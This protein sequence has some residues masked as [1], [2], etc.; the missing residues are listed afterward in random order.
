MTRTWHHA[1][2]ALSLDRCLVMAVVNVTPDSFHDGGRWIVE[3]RSRPNV[4]VVVGQCRRWVEQGADIL[5]VGGESTRPGADPVDEATEL[6]R[7]LPIIE[8]LRA[9]PALA[10]VPISVDTRHAVV[11]RQALKAGAAIVNDISG[12]ADPAM[13]EVVAATG[14]GLV[15]SHLRGEPATMQARV[16][17]DDLLGE[18]ADE[19]E[20]AVARA[21]AAGVAREQIVLDP[22]IGFGKTGAQSAAL[23]AASEFLEARCGFPVLIGASRKRFLGVLAGDKPVEERELASVVAAVVAAAHGAAVVRVHDVAQTVEALRVASGISAALADSRS[24]LR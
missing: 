9:D 14:A 13:A 4:S 20:Q 2:A 12:L 19:L 7:V 23:V 10:S 17:F 24:K 16:Q 3:S 5:D 22:G 21:L 6:A 8:A 11:A 18:I 1:H 15:I